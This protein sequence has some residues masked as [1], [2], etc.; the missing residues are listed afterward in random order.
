MLG[1]VKAGCE[2][3]FS[4]SLLPLHRGLHALKGIQLTDLASGGLIYMKKTEVT[5]VV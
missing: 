4:M 2:I 5:Y 3:R 1:L